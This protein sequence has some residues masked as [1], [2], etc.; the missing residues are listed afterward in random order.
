MYV[1]YVYLH[2]QIWISLKRILL[3]LRWN[4][5]YTCNKTHGA[6]SRKSIISF[7]LRNVA[8]LLH[9][10]LRTLSIRMMIFSD[11]PGWRFWTIRITQEKK[12]KGVFW[13]CCMKTIFDFLSLLYIAIN[14]VQINC[15][16]FFMWRF[17]Y[18]YSIFL[19]LS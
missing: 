9:K 8:R 10:T 13:L 19:P 11:H 3:L 15:I 6:H 14:F 4:T 17:I 1:Y 18:C 5:I 16:I 12:L 2:F 7:C